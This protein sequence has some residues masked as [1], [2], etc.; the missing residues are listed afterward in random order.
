M[1]EK[2]TGTSFIIGF[3]IG[4]AAGATIGFL[5]APKTGAETRALLK[6]KAIETE[7]KAAEVAGK[8]KEAAIKVE[9]RVEEKLHHK[10]AAE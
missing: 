5:Y 10:S 3:L 7:R 6:E 2:D 1:T 4:A 9:K 8:A